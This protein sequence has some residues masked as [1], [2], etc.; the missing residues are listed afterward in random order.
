[1]NTSPHNT[2]KTHFEVGT[3][4]EVNLRVYN[5]TDR[6]LP[7]Q[8]RWSMPGASS[9]SSSSS[10]SG[11]LSHASSLGAEN[12]NSN[13][14]NN[15]N[16]SSN[17]NNRPPIS[18]YP[19]AAPGVLVHGTTSFILG[20]VNSK[21]GY[22]DCKV[23]V[24]A[25]CPGMHSLYGFVV[26]DESSGRQWR[27]PPLGTFYVQPKDFDSSSLKSSGGG[28]DDTSVS[29]E[30]RLSSFQEQV[31]EVDNL[32]KSLREA[33][34]KKLEEEEINIIKNAQ[35]ELDYSV[36]DGFQRM[37]SVEDVDTN[38]T[39]I[40][41]LNK[42]SGGVEELLPLDPISL[43]VPGL[44]RQSTGGGIT[45]PDGS[46]LSNDGGDMSPIQHDESMP[47]VIPGL[48]RQSTGGGITAPDGSRL[49][50]DGG[51]QTISNMDDDRLAED[52]LG[53]MPPVIPG[54]FRQSTGGG[55]H[56]SNDAAGTM[57]DEP[58]DSFLQQDENL[59]SPSSL[60][61]HNEDHQSPQDD[62][63]VH[64][65]DLTTNSANM[66][67]SIMFGDDSSAASQFFDASSQA[68]A[69]LFDQDP[70]S[71]G[72]GGGGFEDDDSSSSSLFALS[73]NVTERPTTHDDNDDEFLEENGDG[74]GG[75]VVP[76]TT[77]SNDDVVEGTI[78]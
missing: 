18:V 7:L 17:N 55:I 14:N 70:I 41:Q 73:S 4:V 74:G 3:S 1:V 40:S 59:L 35:T 48:F 72:D 13:N 26:I 39:I 57:V 75:G 5:Y 53:E 42:V 65:D 69:S 22:Q 29:D 32:D 44:F 11:A 23:N 24:L 45:A 36:D 78:E 8:L 62:M 50:N 19:T 77:E 51:D 46:R 38:E 2:L 6:A 52:S 15:N 60:N 33:Q 54:L 67:E 66:M 68:A 34:V 21:G 58:L 25:L 43:E 49:S 12:S 9:S 71:T 37:A 64:N 56:G 20:T 16:N 30:R 61:N 47:P 63:D 28:G 10:H 31:M 76:L 27:Q